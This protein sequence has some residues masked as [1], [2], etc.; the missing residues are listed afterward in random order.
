MGRTFIWSYL[1]SDPKVLEDG[2]PD[3]PVSEEEEVQ[4]PA[5]VESGL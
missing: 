3:V 2:L 5:P 4:A 1:E